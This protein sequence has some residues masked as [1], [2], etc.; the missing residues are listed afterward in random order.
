MANENLF[1]LYALLMGI[2]ITFVYDLLRI[3][4]RVLI[5][6]QFWVSVEDLIFWCFCAIEVFWLMYHES[7]GTL[8]WFAVIGAV[9]GMALYKKT[10]SGFLVKYVSFGLKK[11]FAFLWKIIRFFLKPVFFVGKKV[12]KA[13]KAAKQRRKK[14]YSKARNKLTGYLKMLKIGLYKE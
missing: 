10:L 6:N 14:L 4:R 9:I 3:W 8:R 13:K 12:N 11:I 7:N 1:L 5:H 2:F